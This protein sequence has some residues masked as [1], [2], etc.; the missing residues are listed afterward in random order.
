[1]FLI[2]LTAFCIVAVVVFFL[3]MKDSFQEQFGKTKRKS[4]DEGERYT[5]REKSTIGARLFVSS[6]FGAVAMLLGTEALMLYDN[7]CIV[8]ILPVSPE[9]LG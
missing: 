1:V 4:I 2:Q 3:T 5:W 8:A 7:L 6:C 9:S